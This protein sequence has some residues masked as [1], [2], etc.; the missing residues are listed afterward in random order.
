MNTSPQAVSKLL[1][2]T[3]FT[4][5]ADRRR[6]GTLVQRAIGGKV[7]VTLQNDKEHI[8]N[9]LAADAAEVLRDHGYTVMQDD[10]ILYVN[11]VRP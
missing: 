8:A 6:E 4:I 11:K 1:K 10:A 5:V 7:C 9:A 2:A 3:G